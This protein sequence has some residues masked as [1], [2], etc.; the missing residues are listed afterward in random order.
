MV[1]PDA[2][3]CPLVK[4]YT[5]DARPQLNSLVKLNAPILG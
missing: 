4:G 2:R 1:Y 5:I 3:K